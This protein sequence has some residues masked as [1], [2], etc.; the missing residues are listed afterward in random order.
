MLHR[1]DMRTPPQPKRP[2]A[3]NP[4]KMAERLTQVIESSPS[5][6]INSL[7]EAPFGI[8]LIERPEQIFTM[9]N[10]FYLQMVSQKREDLLGKSVSQAFPGLREQGIPKILKHVFESGEPYHASDCR[11]TMPLNGQFVDRYYSFVYHPIRRASKKIQGVLV[12]ALDSTNQVL[13]HRLLESEKTQIENE[14]ENFRN[15]F[16]QSPEMVCILTGPNHK[17]EFVNETHAKL[18]G[19]DATGL[20]YSEAQ[21]EAPQLREIFDLVY[22]TGETARY[23]ELPI[24]VGKTLRHFDLTIAARRDLKQTIDGIMILGGDVSERVKARQQA[25]EVKQVLLAEK[26]R[27]VAIKEALRQAKAAAEAAIETKTAFLANMS[28]EIRTPL[29]AILGFIGLLNDTA[30][31]ESE[32]KEYIQIINRNGT[33]LT[34][35]IDD[36]LDISKIESG[37]LQLEYMNFDLEDLL[38]E[39]ISLFPGAQKAKSVEILCSFDP[40]TPRMIKSDQTRLRQILINL[41]GNAVKFTS[42]GRVEIH[43]KPLSRDS[44]ISHLEFTV[45]D[46][47]IGMQPDQAARLF[48]PFSQGDNS[49]TRTFGG[50]G[51][52]LVLS[53]RLARALDGDVELVESSPQSGSTFVARIRIEPV[54]RFDVSSFRLTLPPV[55]EKTTENTAPI[56]VLIV[57]DADENRL[58]IG[59]VLTRAKMIVDF[60]SD[61]EQGVRKAKSGDFDVVL[62]D[63]QMP[64]MDG[65]AATRYLRQEGYRRP[66]L[67]LTAHALAAERK[68][69]LESGCDR[70]LTKPLDV[71]LLIDTIKQCA[72]AQRGSSSGIAS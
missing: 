34:K 11:V 60:A 43:V 57:E 66:I 51:L 2:A 35:I 68:R 71:A 39:V 61:G 25:E 45:K 58:L 3:T 14:R 52:G 30:S 67:A 10:D 26:D 7:M 38:Q 70:H 4:V 49:T 23:I 59:E 31:T 41:L 9:A 21:P 69:I 44:E 28:H 27:E 19:F 6:L 32:K 22:R 24:F 72:V 46:S 55:E 36:I 8:A 56:R 65:Y 64:V 17:F 20:T 54:Q 50:S 29:S 16:R 40:R 47:G 37:R 33:L 18:L 1:P 48:Q 13:C 63:M 12:V 15:L 5:D 42:K 62:M 53:R